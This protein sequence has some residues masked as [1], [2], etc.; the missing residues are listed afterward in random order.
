MSKSAIL[1]YI[2][3]GITILGVLGY[4]FV[5][6]FALTPQLLIKNTLNAVSFIL[7]ITGIWIVLPKIIRRIIYPILSVFI[8]QS[9][10]VERSNV[11]I[12]NFSDSLKMKLFGFFLLVASIIIGLLNK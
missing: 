12:F 9:T 6:T 2:F 1:F 7:F 5:Q 11:Y 8:S 10:T 3:I 4:Y